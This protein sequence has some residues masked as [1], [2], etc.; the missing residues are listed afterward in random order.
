MRARD[1][2]FRT[3]Q[4]ERL[5]YQLQATTWPQLWARLEALRFRAAIVGAHGTGKTTL[6]EELG[7]RLRER[8]WLTLFIRRDAEHRT[9]SPGFVRALVSDVTSQT[10]ILFDGAEQLRPLAWWRFQRCSW[11][12]GGLIVTTH[13][14]GR[15]PTLIE[16]RTSAGLLAD[17]ARQ[18]TDQADD[19]VR[20]T[21]ESLFR[22]HRGNLR[23]ALREW[24]D[25][26]ATASHPVTP[27]QGPATQR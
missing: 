11:Q 24:Y 19:G 9:F 14:P 26:W 21:A 1:N 20:V 18:L 27:G 16:C 15:L 25:R 6:L 4:V 5:S 10:I 8:G 3:E 22:R 2:P 23:E 17:L 7:S 12:A 13:R